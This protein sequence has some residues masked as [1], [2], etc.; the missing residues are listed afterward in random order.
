MSKTTDTTE[1]PT[2][3]IDTMTDDEFETYVVEL[4]AAC[5][6]RKAARRY[7]RRDR[8]GRFVKVHSVEAMRAC[9]VFINA[10]DGTTHSH[11][12]CGNLKGVE[13][14]FDTEQHGWLC[15]ACVTFPENVWFLAR[16]I[17]P[18]QGTQTC[19]TCH[20]EKGMRS[21]PT[22]VDTGVRVRGTTCRKCEHAHREQARRD[23]A[24]LAFDLAEAA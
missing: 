3:G 6:P 14:E 8:L 9:Q 18:T 10:A 23:A 4:E 22:A 7:A 13:F 12:R 11:T 16:D 20:T 2:E 1:F 19:D 5:K 17:A 21:F 24:Q 15:D